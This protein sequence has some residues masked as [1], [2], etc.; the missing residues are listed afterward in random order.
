[1][2]ISP[3]DA[4]QPL[5]YW[6]NESEYRRRKLT[7]GGLIGEFLI[8]LWYLV[9]WVILV[10]AFPV[11]FLISWWRKQPHQRKLKAENRQPYEIR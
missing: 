6:K 9:R 2:Y 3:P 8:L 10:V 11:R 4:N 1:M 7:N 5:E